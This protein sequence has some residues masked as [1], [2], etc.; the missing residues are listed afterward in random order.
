MARYS[1]GCQ[2]E[3]GLA[4]EQAL[5]GVLAAWQEK[6]G[7]HRRACS[8]ASRGP[9]I[10]SS[11]HEKCR[12]KPTPTGHKTTNLALECNKASSWGVSGNESIELVDVYTSPLRTTSFTS[13]KTVFCNYQLTYTTSSITTKTSQTATYVRTF[14]IGA[15]SVGCALV[16]VR[17]CAFIDVCNKAKRKDV[18][19]HNHDKYFELL[20]WIYKSRWFVVTQ[21]KS[22]VLQKLVK[23]LLWRCATTYWF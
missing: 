12:H 2:W 16:C 15:K 14:C 5:Q 13:W 22:V 8:Q 11:Y 17:S 19:F 4:C 21:A 3:P 1:E 18:V 23:H 9:K 20:F 10:S 6:E 7:L